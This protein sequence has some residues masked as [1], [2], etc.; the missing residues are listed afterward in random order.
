MAVQLIQ[1][2]HA[3]TTSSAIECCC[4]STRSGR[5]C[6][7]PASSA[8]WLPS[9][10][11]PPGPASGSRMVTLANRWDIPTRNY[12]EGLRLSVC[13]CDSIDCINLK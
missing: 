9:T 5:S 2:L 11:K 1:W 7:C 3:S 10:R 4:S 13:M 8:S 12:W 6:R